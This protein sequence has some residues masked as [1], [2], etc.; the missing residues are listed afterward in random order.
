MRRATFGP[1]RARS[2]ARGPGE[3]LLLDPSRVWE[4][5]QGSRSALKA[6]HF[7]LRTASY[8]SNQSQQPS[9][10]CS[11]ST[12]FLLES[13]HPWAQTGPGVLTVAHFCLR[14][15][16]FGYKQG[17]EPNQGSRS[18]LKT[19]PFCLCAQTGTGA[20]PRGQVCCKNNFL[21]LIGN[22]YF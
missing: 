22:S 9:Q 12:L 2:T 11:K 13:N 10:V 3:Q 15:A 5:C 17:Q 18:V 8:R 6:A 1:T 20:P 4:P 21:F 7:C 19:G 16:T 14:S